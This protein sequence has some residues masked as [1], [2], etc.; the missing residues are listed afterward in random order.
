MGGQEAKSGISFKTIMAI[1]II[2][3]I[4][5]IAYNYKWQQDGCSKKR[6]DDSV[7]ANDIGNDIRN[8]PNPDPEIEKLITTIHQM[9]RANY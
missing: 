3:V 5:F 7:P 4:L 9:Q 2:V 1:V 6:T 8:E